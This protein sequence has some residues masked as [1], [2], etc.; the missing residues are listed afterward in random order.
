MEE[1]EESE[2]DL[3]FVGTCADKEISTIS[4]KPGK[5]YSYKRLCRLIKNQYPQL[6]HDLALEYYN[7]WWSQTNKIEYQNRSYLH[8][9]HSQIDYLFLILE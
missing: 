5:R 3:H 2:I 1:R 7:P 6:Y 4:E 9:V 8:L